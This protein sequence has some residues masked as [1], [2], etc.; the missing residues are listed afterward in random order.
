MGREIRYAPA[1]H[2][3]HLWQMN[4]TWNERN[5]SLKLR[6]ISRKAIATD[7]KISPESFLHILTNSLGEW[8]VHA[9]WLPHKPKDDQRA[10]R[11]ILATIH[12]Q[13]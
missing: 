9:K 1:T 3:Q 6:S 8:K 2:P 7:V 10:M 12:L 13:H 11:V 5:L 4:A